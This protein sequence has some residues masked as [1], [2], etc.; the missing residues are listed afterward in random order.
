MYNSGPNDLKIGKSKLSSI[1]I[2]FI[3]VKERGIKLNRKTS[4]L[5]TKIL[6]VNP[7]S[8]PSKRF[9]QP[10]IAN[11]NV[12]VIAFATNLNT[13]FVQRNK[14]LKLKMWIIDKARLGKN[15]WISCVKASKYVIAIRYP[16]INP[17]MVV[18][19]RINPRKNPLIINIAENIIMKMSI[20]F[21]KQV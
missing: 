14:I 9:N 16:R 15:D 3:K 17:M 21:I 13:I 2:V 11:F 18:S 19:S 12:F 20:E 6:F 5:N 4:I 7:S 1:P 10:S 8:P